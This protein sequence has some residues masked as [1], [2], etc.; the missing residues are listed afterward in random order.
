MNDLKELEIDKEV[1]KKI[2][3]ICRFACI[4]T[5]IKNGSIINVKGSNIPYISPHIITIKCNIKHLKGNI[6]TS[7][8]N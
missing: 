7:K 1:F 3:M 8:K 2:E 5:N 6:I 4:N